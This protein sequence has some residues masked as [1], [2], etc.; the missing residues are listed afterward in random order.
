MHC[1]P[2][3][4]DLNTVLCREV[5]EKTGMTEG[6]EVTTGVFESAASIVSKTALVATCG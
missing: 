6:L 4:H 3:F 2:A 1:L 5:M